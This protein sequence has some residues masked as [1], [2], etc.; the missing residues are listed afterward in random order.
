MTGVDEEDAFGASAEEVG[1]AD[2]V[3]IGGAFG[4]GAAVRAVEPLGRG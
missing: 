2:T 3:E 4:G 1:F